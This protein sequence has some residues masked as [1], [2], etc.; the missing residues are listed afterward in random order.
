VVC[1]MSQYEIRVST[2]IGRLRGSIKHLWNLSKET[3]L[4]RN[5]CKNLVLEI[6]K[7][8]KIVWELAQ[9]FLIDRIG[10][11][12]PSKRLL[13]T[14]IAGKDPEALV[15]EAFRYPAFE[16]DVSG[17]IS[18]LDSPE[19]Y[20]DKDVKE[21]I[22]RLVE[23]LEAELSKVEVKLNM[24]Y[25]LPKISEFITTFPQFTDNWAVAAC[26]LTAMDIMVNR[27]LE[28]LGLERGTGFRDNYNKLLEKFK[29]Q[30]V[31]ISELEKRLPNVFWDIRNKVIHLGY[32]PT[33]NEVE[34]ITSYIEKVLGTLIYLK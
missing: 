2:E 12:D 10:G 30:N 16:S 29:E 27:K 31:E 5:D 28:E 33:Y 4:N 21:N 23:N 26:Y 25:G 18:R 20:K 6:R 15:K 13:L 17:V 7:S 22:S 32:S 11:L 34:T 1:K 14:V 3:T 8:L 24:K 19:Y 9:D